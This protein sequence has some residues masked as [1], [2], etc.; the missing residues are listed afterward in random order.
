MLIESRLS[1]PFPSI[2]SNPK[3]WSWPGKRYPSRSVHD[4]VFEHSAACRGCTSIVATSYASPNEPLIAVDSLASVPC[5]DHAQASLH[6]PVENRIN[7]TK[8]GR[9]RPAKHRTF[10]V[11]DLY[12]L[13]SMI[14][15]PL[16]SSGCSMRIP[17]VSSPSASSTYNRRGRLIRC[18]Y[19]IIGWAVRLIMIWRPMHQ[20]MVVHHFE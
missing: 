18:Q 20:W 1:I 13:S 11:I 10:A 15:F 4:T 6:C 19:L 2:K 7:I 17:C 14:P 12:S 3:R 9:P 8:G 16:E 5:D